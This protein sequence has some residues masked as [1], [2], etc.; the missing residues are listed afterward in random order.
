MNIKEIFKNIRTFIF[1]FDGVI[2]DG[3]VLLTADGEYLR[4]IDSKDSYA[5]QHAVRSGYRVAIIT[6]G[7]STFIKS[8]MESLGVKHVFLKSSDK[9]EVYENFLLMENISPNEVLYMGDDLPDYPVLMSVAAK[10]CPHDAVHEVREICNYVAN[11]IGGKGA[12]RE[13]IE[14][15]MRTQD[16]WIND[17]TYSW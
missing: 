4:K 1:D 2:A 15:V 7:S 11:A 14:Q 6:G 5:I 8:S 10:T 12:V 3:S 16:K 17:K 9:L 13:V